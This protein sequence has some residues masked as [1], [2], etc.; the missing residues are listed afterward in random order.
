MLD[1]GFLYG[2]G[3]FETIRVH[4][5]APFRLK[6]HVQRLQQGLEILG[7]E[8]PRGFDRIRA[9]V[10]ALVDAEGLRE[11]LLRV[12]ATGPHPEAKLAGTLVMTTRPLPTVPD[13][14]VLRVAESVCRTPGA[15]SRCKT[16]SR[17]LETMALREARGHG[18]FDAVLLNT[19]GNVAETT[20]R[21]L[22]AVAGGALFTPSASEGALEGITRGTVLERARVEGLELREGAVTVEAIL[23]ADEVFLT[24]SGVG[25]LGVHGIHARSYAPVPGPVTERLAAAYAKDLDRES[26]W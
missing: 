9:G 3:C 19:R 22:F 10:R 7:V 21:N 6:A 5:G 26:R 16:T 1:R 14:V 8:P 11:G 18:A 20:S 24:G 17:V 4:G 12:T 25:V 15:L 2:E 23:H 13:R